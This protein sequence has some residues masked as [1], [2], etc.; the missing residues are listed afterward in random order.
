MR[1][2]EERILSAILG[3]MGTRFGEVN[4]RLD[5]MDATLHMHGK[6]IAAGTKTIAGFTEWTG[7]ADS[8]YRRV[9]DELA[10][11]KIRLAKLERPA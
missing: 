10:D 7:K 1:E 8:D 11:M 9:L 6:M 2:T 4:G 3:E 5:R